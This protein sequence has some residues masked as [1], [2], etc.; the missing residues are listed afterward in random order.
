MRT[1]CIHEQSMCSFANIAS[2]RERLLLILKHLLV[3]ILTRKHVFGRSRVQISARRPVI[4]TETFSCFFSV[5]PSECRYSTL[6][7]GSDRF[8]PT[9]FWFIISYHPFIRRYIVLV[10]ETASLNKLQTNR[11]NTCELIQK[12]MTV[13]FSIKFGMRVEFWSLWATRAKTRCW[14]EAGVQL[15]CCK[16]A[17]VLGY[18]CNFRI[19]CKPA[20]LNV[21]FGTAV[22]SVSRCSLP[23]PFLLPPPLLPSNHRTRDLCTLQ[24]PVP[25]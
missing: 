13:V 15:C 22:C 17:P 19:H 8:H 16:V 4:L 11:T 20:F 14:S 7:L 24:P 12:G 21:A 9:P 5:P 25:L 6:K 23:P 18:C 2:H 10:T 3:R 1:W